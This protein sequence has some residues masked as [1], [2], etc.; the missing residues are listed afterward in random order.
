M[1]A[2]DRQIG[3]LLDN[4]C[5]DS[6]KRFLTDRGYDAHLVRDVMADDT[7]DPAVADF[8]VRNELILITLDKDFHQQKY[9]KPRYDGLMRLSFAV[10]P[11]T[12]LTRLEVQI[13]RLEREFH[14]CNPGARFTFVIGKDKIIINC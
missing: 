13:E 1:T 12:A 14:L 8:A 7:P 6:I 9:L 3:F 2:R 5:P 4:N 10:P 11:P